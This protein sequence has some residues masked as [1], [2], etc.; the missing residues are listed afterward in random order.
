MKGMLGILDNEV[1]NVN[2]GDPVSQ[3]NNTNTK[4]SAQSNK[5]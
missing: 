1:N 3:G 4:D 5:R 2:A